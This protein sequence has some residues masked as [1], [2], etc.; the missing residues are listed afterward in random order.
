MSSANK[1]HTTAAPEGI[2]RVRITYVVRGSR[3]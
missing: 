3:F 1:V 2:Y